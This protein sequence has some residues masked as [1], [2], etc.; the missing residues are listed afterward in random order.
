MAA[1]GQKRFLVLTRTA[2]YLRI[3]FHDGSSVLVDA[4]DFAPVAKDAP[5]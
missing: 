2:H 5:R 4:A 3:G 1:S